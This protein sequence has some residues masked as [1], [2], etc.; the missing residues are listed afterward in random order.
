MIQIFATDL[1]T[2]KTEEIKDLYWFEENYVHNF[3]D[4][5]LVFQ[6]FTGLKDKN[7]RGSYEGDII[8]WS[9]FTHTRDLPGRTGSSVAVCSSAL[10]G[11]TD[12]TRDRPRRYVHP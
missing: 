6:Q 4:E 8:E 9:I 12:T 10:Y 11:A 2:G 5:C 3:N 7:G 1:K